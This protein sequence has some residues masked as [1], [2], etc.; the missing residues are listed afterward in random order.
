MPLIHYEEALAAKKTTK[1][2][3]MKKYVQNAMEKGHIRGTIVVVKDGK[4][5]Q[6]SYGYG[7]YKKRLKA[8]NPKVLYPLG[9]LQKV[10]TSA[11]ITQLIYQGKFNQNT[12]IS[13]WYPQMKNS[14]K[15]TVG[16]LMT[17]TS[18]INVVGTES[19][20]GINYSEQGAINRVISQV[21]AQSMTKR[22]RFNY[23]N[24]NY[25]LLAGIIRKVTGKSYAANLKSR[26][27][28]PLKLK[29]TYIYTKIPKGKTDGVSY[30]YAQGKNYQDPRV[31]PK[32][33]TTQLV[34][35]GDVFSTPMDYYKIICGL[36]N[37]KVLTKKQFKYMTHLKAKSNET[38]YSG[39]VY[40]RRNGKLEI[41]Y[42]N[43]G[44]T[45]FS[46]WLQL[47][48]DNKNGIVMFLNQTISKNKNKDIGYK[49]LKKIK[50]NTFVNR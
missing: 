4:A 5:E 32:T 7:Y 43:F 33:L 12:K 27:I 21:N 41:A 3:S 11:M 35:A 2:Q 47:T 28:K 15:I 24:A 44:D 46:D 14:S 19:N 18:G 29:D 10:I 37:G 17:H 25:I 48:S 39:G 26:I 30:T 13:R 49:I 6:I 22:G 34:G 50:A 40:M 20:A 42:G 45:Y 31:A 8:G 16:N 23:N 38:T 36:Q 9:S 1:K